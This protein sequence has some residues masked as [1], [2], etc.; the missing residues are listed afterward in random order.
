MPNYTIDTTLDGTRPPLWQTVPV[1]STASGSGDTGSGNTGSGGTWTGGTWTGG[2]WSGDTGSG[3]IRYLHVLTDIFQYVS[4][5]E[6][7]P[8]AD[9]VRFQNLAKRWH[10]E[11]KYLSSDHDIAMNPAYQSIIGMGDRAIPLILQ[12]LQRKT[13]PNPWFWAL[14]MITREN[15]VPP[16]EAGDMRRMRER[17]LDW[18][19]SRG[20]ITDRLNRYAC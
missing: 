11:T 2:T 8:R 7:Q 9:E 19:R 16:E 5:M 4:G 1:Q 6:A 20:Y 14:T 17:W 12:D 13:E 15:P 10:R 3:G 18:G